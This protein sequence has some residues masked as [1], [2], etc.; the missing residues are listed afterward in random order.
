MHNS[1]CSYN[2]KLR[3]KKLHK[4]K[5]DIRDIAS[6]LVRQITDIK[7]LREKHVGETTVELDNSLCRLERYAFLSEAEASYLTSTQ[8]SQQD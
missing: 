7:K 4:N 3:G 6:G 8:G 5:K 2:S 1:L